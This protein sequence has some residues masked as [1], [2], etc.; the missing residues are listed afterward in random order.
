MNIHW[1]SFGNHSNSSLGI[2]KEPIKWNLIDYLIAFF[3]VNGLNFSLTFQIFLARFI[4]KIHEFH[5]QSIKFIYFHKKWTIYIANY[6]YFTEFFFYNSQCS[7]K[8]LNSKITLIMVNHWM[9]NILKILI[10]NFYFW[11][12]LAFYR[13][14]ELAKLIAM[15]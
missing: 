2:P 6:Q 13:K 9:K 8:L 4:L 3:L 10:Q 11:N 14:R 15:K 12:W 5:T 1:F 7:L